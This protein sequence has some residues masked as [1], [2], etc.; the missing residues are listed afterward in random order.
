MKDTGLQDIHGERL[1]ASNDESNTSVISI[2]GTWFFV[3]FGKDY[4]NLWLKSVN[5]E[6]FSADGLDS[7]EF[8]II[9]K[10][11]PELLEGE[12]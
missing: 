11:D 2:D 10:L 9:K 7:R 3:Y 5:N 6:H 12:S 8:E 4:K 1:Y